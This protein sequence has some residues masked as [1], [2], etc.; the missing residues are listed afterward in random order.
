MKRKHIQLLFVLLL[1]I[2]MPMDAQHFR[3]AFLKKAFQQLKL[4]QHWKT[5]D[6]AAN[7][8]YINVGDRQVLVRTSED[9]T[10]EHVGIPLFSQEMQRL[11]PS[12]V[13]DC[14]EQ[15]L[16]DHVYHIADNTLPREQLVFEQGSWNDLLRV[17]STDECQIENQEDKFYC[18]AWLRQGQPWLSLRCPVNYE[19]LAGSTRREMEQ[20]FV[21]E[22]KKYNPAP[23]ATAQI[24]PTLPLSEIHL[25]L[26]LYGNHLEN[27]SMNLLQLIAYCQAKGCKTQLVTDKPEGQPDAALL[28]FRNPASGYSH[29]LHLKGKRLKDPQSKETLEGRLF[30]FIPINNVDDLFAAPPAETDRPKR[31]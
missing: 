3:T 19:L 29:L 5:S 15:L 26:S 2:A 17:K 21:K 24:D 10:I 25:S 28:Y 20:T 11:M 23:A 6:A 1:S 31:F 22:L 16:L 4:A 9:G 7:V 8:Q 18:V 30:L 13:Y 27:I 12:P 14:I